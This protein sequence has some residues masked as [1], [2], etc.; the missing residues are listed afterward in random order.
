MVPALL[1]IV[2]LL[3]LAI[4]LKFGTYGASALVGATLLSFGSILL[5]DE[6][7]YRHPVFA[8]SVSV[9]LAIIAGFQGYLG[10]RTRKSKRLAGLE[11]LVGEKGVSRT[12]IKNRGTVFVRGEY[13]QATSREAIPPGAL[14]SVER[15]E[16]LLLFVREA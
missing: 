10:L 5:M 2:A 1:I 6:S 11:E 8:V 7:G 3:L 9:A 14:V 12:E 15:V 4:E 16:G 13:W